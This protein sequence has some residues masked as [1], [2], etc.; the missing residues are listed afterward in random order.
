M[1]TF[2]VAI[3]VGD[4]Q[5]RRWEALEAL[6]D[7]GAT[8]TVIP[9]PILKGLGLEPYDRRPFILADERQVEMEIGLAWVRAEGRSTMATVIFGEGDQAL[10]GAHTLEGLGLGVDPLRRRLVPVP[11][12]LMASRAPSLLL[13]TNNPGKA[14]ELRQLLAGCGWEIVTP[15]EVG[16]SLPPERGEGYEENARLKALAAARA[17]GMMALADDSGLEVEALGGGPGPL[18]ARYAGPNADDRER[19]ALLLERLRG[20]PPEGRRAR[21]RCTIA[22]ASPAG[23]VSTFQ[24]EVQG[25][26]AEAPRGENGFGYDPIFYL[27]ELGRTLAELSPEEKNAISHRGRAA[28]AARRFLERVSH[29]PA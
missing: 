25:L 12:L 5:G 1:G 6:V 13:A 22:I 8:Y 2:R 21:F 19:V 16:I 7:S 24:G 3:E 20:V 28:R 10:L 23:E 27:P 17:A 29:E 15:G 14:R 11:G 9:A 26:I 18:S 4:L